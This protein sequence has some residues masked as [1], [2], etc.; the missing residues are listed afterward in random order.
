MLE[1]SSCHLAFKVVFQLLNKIGNASVPVQTEMP[2]I[3]DRCSE[4]PEKTLSRNGNLIYEQLCCHY[5]VTCI[6]T[7]QV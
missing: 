5:L 7:D 4:K 2:V 6:D 1:T 3:S